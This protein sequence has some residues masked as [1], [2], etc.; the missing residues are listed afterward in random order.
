[1]HVRVVLG[2]GAICAALGLTACGEASPEE[3]RDRTAPIVSRVVKEVQG[4]LS[5]AEQM[6]EVKQLLETLEILA[7]GL[8]DDTLK[9]DW[10]SGM[11]DDD[12]AAEINET[13]ARYVL[14]E[15]NVESASPDSVTFLLRGAQV[16]QG[17]TVT[18][19]SAPLG[20]EP[21][22]TTSH[23]TSQECIEAVD[24]LELR[25]KA[26]LVGSE[27]VDL[28]FGIG[29]SPTV[30]TLRLRPDEVTV[31]VSLAGAGVAAER[32]AQLTG[33]QIDLP[34]TMKGVLSASLKIHAPGDISLQ[35]AVKQ[36]VQV[37]TTVDQGAFQLRM[38]ARDPVVSLRLRQSPPSVTLDVDWGALEL[39]CPARQVWEQA[40]GTVALA[41]QG[42]SASLASDGSGG[43]AIKGVSLGSGTSRL[44]LSNTS[45]VTSLVEVDLNPS[46][47]RKLDLA[48]APWQDGLP[49][50]EV[51]PLLDLRV[52]INLAPIEAYLDEP[53][54]PWA[55]NEVFVARLAAATGNPAVAPVRSTATFDGGLKVLSGRLTLQSQVQPA[56]ITVPQGSCLVWHDADAGSHP[57]LGHFD[58]GPCN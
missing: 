42:L 23:E 13:L 46:D 50:C 20:G 28:G 29:G 7:P 33:E 55:R 36:A 27:G 8:A 32:V 39:A 54:E 6:S 16:C 35:S 43:L 17:V 34:E 9:A 44:M 21:Q 25:I 12:L 19:C 4:A 30:I 22:C 49:R 38:A 5:A 47:G 15:A 48:L 57:L 26:T 10:D 11:S 14:T 37:E 31:E 58:S 56:T 24:R 51:S 3:V 45:L 52:K 1:M 18:E 41:L 2:L 53:L 40:S